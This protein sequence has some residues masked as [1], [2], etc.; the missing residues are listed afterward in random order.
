[1]TE[2]DAGR[3]A[4][5]FAA[6]SQMQIRTGLAA[7]F[8]GDLHQLADAGLI[9]LGSRVAL[10]DVLFNIVFQD[11]ARVVTGKTICHLRQVVGPK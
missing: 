2:P 8:H 5:M 11:A 3:V 1:M 7:L 4:A 9:Q 6:D 10:V